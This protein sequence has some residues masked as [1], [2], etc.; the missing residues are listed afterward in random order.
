M[1]EKMLGMLQG[2]EIIRRLVML[3]DCQVMGSAGLGSP[4]SITAVMPTGS[5]GPFALGAPKLPSSGAII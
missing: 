4:G 5:P 3:L 1:D 2:P